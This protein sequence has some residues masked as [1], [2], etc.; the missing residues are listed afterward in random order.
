MLRPA[1]TAAAVTRTRALPAWARHASAAVI[2]IA[3]L[4]L[5]RAA[6]P[7][8]PAAYPF[9]LFTVAVLLATSTAGEP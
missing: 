8:L 1:F 5:R 9:L 4:L 6:D 7:V 3:V 2:V